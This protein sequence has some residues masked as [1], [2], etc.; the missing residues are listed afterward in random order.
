MTIYR[1]VQNN[2]K[3]CESENVWF[4]SKNKILKLQKSTK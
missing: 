4:K 2:E 1:N 3:S